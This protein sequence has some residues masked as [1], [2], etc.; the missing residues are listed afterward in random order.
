MEEEG[1]LETLRGFRK[2]VRLVQLKPKAAAEPEAEP[3]AK[4]MISYEEQVYNYESQCE[5]AFNNPK[6]YIFII[7]QQWKR[8]SIKEFNIF[9][10]YFLWKNRGNIKLIFWRRNKSF[11]DSKINMQIFQWKSRGDLFFKLIFYIF[12]VDGRGGVQPA[13][14]QRPPRGRQA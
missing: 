3:A 4:K 5:E 12:C 13:P 9:N 11:T 8:K 10:L 1:G 6:V 7:I 2:Q 14:R